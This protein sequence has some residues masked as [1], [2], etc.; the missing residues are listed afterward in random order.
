MLAGDRVLVVEDEPLVAAGLRDLLAEAEGKPVGPAS[1]VSS[2][3]SLK[4]Q[5]LVRSKGD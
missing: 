4:P 3:R 5:A 1:S 2:G